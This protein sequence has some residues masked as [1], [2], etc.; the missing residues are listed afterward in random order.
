MDNGRLAKELAIHESVNIR[1]YDL[2]PYELINFQE[3][4]SRAKIIGKPVEIDI[5]KPYECV[6][7]S[8][9]PPT[10]RTLLRNAS[11]ANLVT[12]IANLY[13]QPRI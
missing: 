5:E 6:A 10:R 13:R 1:K 12:A 4:F 9:D 11:F 2:D 3:E 7:P 8:L